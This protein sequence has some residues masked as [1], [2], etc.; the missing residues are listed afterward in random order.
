MAAAEYDEAERARIVALDAEV[1]DLARTVARQSPELQAA[2]RG[3]LRERA[4]QILDELSS[5]SPD[6]L[7]R[8]QVSLPEARLDAHF[9]IKEAPLAASLRMGRYLRTLSVL[10]N[11]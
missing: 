7:A 2:E 3:R 5:C 8:A 4:T 10:R 11:Q 9:V 1:R 6:A